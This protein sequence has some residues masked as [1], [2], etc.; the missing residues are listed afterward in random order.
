MPM[1]K[2]TSISQCNSVPKVSGNFVPLLFV[3][4]QKKKITVTFGS[5]TAFWNV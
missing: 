3:D 5:P 2:M 1:E 4:S